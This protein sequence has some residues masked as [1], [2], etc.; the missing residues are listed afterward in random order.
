MKPWRTLWLALA[1]GTASACSPPV[2]PNPADAASDITQGSDV[3]ATMD[4][5]L[6]A[7][8]VIATD[9]S[10]SEIATPAAL[11]Y[12]GAIRPLVEQNCQGCHSTGGIGP[13]DL[14]TYAAVQPL[15]RVIASQVRNR[16][17]PP[18]MPAAGCRDLK[19]S[20]ALTDA[21][22]ATFVQWEAAG[23]PE[24][25]MSEYR[26]ATPRTG[27]TRP[28]PATP[29]QLIVE[30]TEAYLPMQNRTD[31]YH[32]FIV[33][34]ALTTSR[35][36]VGVRVRPGNPGIVHHMLLFEVR[37]SALPALQRLD[38]ATPGPGYTC[39]GGVGIDPGYRVGTN[40]DIADVD[41]Q[42]IHGWAPGGVDGYYP[43]GTGI[44]IKPGS[45]LVMQV[46]YYIPPSK[47]GMTDRT[48]IELFL[49]EPGTTQQALWIPQLNNDFMVPA[50]AGPTDPRSTAVATFRNTLPLRIFGV[51]PHMHQRGHSIH[52]ETTPNTAAGATQCMVNIPSW[53][54]HWQQNYF[55]ALPYRPAVGDTLRTTCVWD[56]TQANQPYVD[57][58]QQ[59]SRELRWGE[60]SDDEMCLNYFYVSL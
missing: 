23:A 26:A 60:G 48:R 37:Q 20:R 1:L 30:P 12:W 14:G 35:D 34:P 42:Q 36:V 31:D 58:V 25:T 10:S 41:V 51:F 32:C 44:R 15:A 55:F 18:W 2:T 33:D 52:V 57:G 54:F 13:M 50:N 17:M 29:G 7:D 8:D 40:G 11:T 45:R 5:P 38:D 4:A 24:G 47:R 46:H 27:T 43:N 49:G 53:D 56:N 16:I 9:A 6:P 3:A 28:L 22:I 19:D 21:E 59:P 39:Y